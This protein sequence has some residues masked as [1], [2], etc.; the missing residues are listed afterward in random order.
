MLCDQYYLRS[1]D[2]ILREVNSKS[3]PFLYILKKRDRVCRDAAREQ[4]VES[5]VR[6]MG[7]LGQMA[8]RG[9]LII[10]AELK[11]G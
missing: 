3:D 2:L 10:A 11:C 7:A 5:S 6:A 8:S 4:T 9:P 1:P